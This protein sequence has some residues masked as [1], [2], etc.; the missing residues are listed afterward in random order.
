[1]IRYI[2]LKFSEKEFKEIEEKKKKLEKKLKEE[3]SWEA[4]LMELL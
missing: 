2:Q 4:F 3:L 1:M